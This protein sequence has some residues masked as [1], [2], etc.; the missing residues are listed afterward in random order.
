MR[1][2]PGWP[3]GP[4]RQHA[5]VAGSPGARLSCCP[6]LGSPSAGWTRAG[7]HG[8]GCLPDT[9]TERSLRRWQLSAQT[10]SVCW[11]PACSLQQCLT[12]HWGWGN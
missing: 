2:G 7:G 6:Q 8:Q 10:P 11:G 3:W 12:E 9:H 1:E 4:L 5:H